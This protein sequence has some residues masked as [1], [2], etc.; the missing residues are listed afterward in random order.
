MFAAKAKKA[1]EA[2]EAKNKDDENCDVDQF[3][4]SHP[5]QGDNPPGI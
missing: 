4:E 1:Q 5:D 2:E 3:G